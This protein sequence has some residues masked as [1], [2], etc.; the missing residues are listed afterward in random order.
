MDHIQRG[1]K[2]VLD[3]ERWV[4][5]SLT[6][7]TPRIAVLVDDDDDNELLSLSWS[8]IYVPGSSFVEALMAL[9]PW[10]DISIDEDFYERYADEND[11]A[12][13]RRRYAEE[14]YWPYDED[15]E[16]AN[17]RFVLKLNE[18]GSAFLTLEAYLTAMELPYTFTMDDLKM[19]V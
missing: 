14:E 12:T 19:P 3:A 6:R 15:G 7:T 11:D 18:L 5:K 10:A 9:F 4:N 13:T 16:V 2:V 8:T 17:Y 1:E